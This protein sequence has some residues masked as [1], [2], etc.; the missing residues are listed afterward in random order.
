MRKT[1]SDEAW[2]EYEYWQCQDKKT[3]KKINKLIKSI[4]RNGYDCEG[5]LEPLTGDL[6]GYYSVHID[7]KN[8]LVFKIEDEEID[9][10]QC[11]SHYR[12][13]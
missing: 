11:G 1:W 6:T 7:E 3:L 10:I 12:D 9:I 2:E 4:D 8:R 5:H 13:K